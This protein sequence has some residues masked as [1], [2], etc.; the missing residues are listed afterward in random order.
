MLCYFLCKGVRLPQTVLISRYL[1]ASCCSARE[2]GTKTEDVESGVTFLP[3]S[4]ME[5][6]SSAGTLTA[7]QPA[8][9]GIFSSSQVNVRRMTE[10][11][12]TT[13]WRFLL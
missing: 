5:L 12:G 7:M 4:L 10:A 9:L 11:L 3:V 13:Y 2:F 6:C 8:G 1:V